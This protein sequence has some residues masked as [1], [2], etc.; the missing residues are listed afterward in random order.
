MSGG[1]RG[2]PST[3]KAD[4]KSQGVP[5]TPVEDLYGMRR[6]HTSLPGKVAP[7]RV[8]LTTMGQDHVLTAC[9]QSKKDAKRGATVGVLKS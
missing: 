1:W 2:Q 8:G 7:A 9:P 6:K 5:M 4:V 3:A